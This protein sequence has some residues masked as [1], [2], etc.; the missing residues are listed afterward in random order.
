[1]EKHR[2]S[3]Y[4]CYVK[5]TC[6]VDEKCQTSSL[7]YQA[8]VTQHDNNKDESYIEL[9]DNTFKA[10]YNGHTNSSQN[11]IYRNVIALSNYIWTLKDK[12]ISYSIK[13]RIMD[14]GR[15]YQPSG[16]NCGLCDLEKF[17][18]IFKPELASLNQRNEV[19]TSCRHR[20]KP[21]YFAM[22]SLYSN[23]LITTHTIN[24]TTQAR[25]KID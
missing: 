7:I 10:S 13:W 8:S 5:E 20:K 22:T 25:C 19:A 11:E 4:N 14:R 24:L 15:A 6:P 21:I 1:M 18:I 3:N 2:R 23:I 12:K 17:Y 9:T 16:K